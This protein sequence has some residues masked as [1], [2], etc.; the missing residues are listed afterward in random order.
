MSMSYVK[1][2]YEWGTSMIERIRAKPKP[3]QFRLSALFILTILVA[4]CSAL[5]RYKSAAGFALFFALL[6]IETIR[7][8]S[9]LWLNLTMIF[10]GASLTSAAMAIGWPVSQSTVGNQPPDQSTEDW[11]FVGALGVVLGVLI[12]LCGFWFFGF[13]VFVWLTEGAAGLREE[14]GKDAGEPPLK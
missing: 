9:P 10:G 8:R 12:L 2:H 5:I 13:H 6:A 7:R 11:Q 4:I 14:L 1:L 3:F